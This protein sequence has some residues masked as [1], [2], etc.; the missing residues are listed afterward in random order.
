MTLQTA[1]KQSE[2]QPLAQSGFV[3]RVL[4]IITALSLALLSS[5]CDPEDIP[6]LAQA[7]DKAALPPPP[8]TSAEVGPQAWLEYPLE[9][10]TIPPEEPVPFVVYASDAEGVAQ[11]EL[12]V[13]GEPLPAT[14][15]QALSPDGSSRL[16]RLD[17]DWQAPAEGEYITE[18]RGRNTAGSYGEPTYVKFCVGSCQ[19]V[20]VTPSPAP[21]QVIPPAPAAQYDLYVRRMDFMQTNPIVGETIELFIMIATDTY[22][23]PGPFFPASYFRWRQGPNFPWQEESCPPNNQY[24]SCEK[25]VT[26]AYDQAG[27]YYVEV[28]ADS[29]QEVAESDLDHNR[30][31]G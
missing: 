19:P 31:L 2:C 14:Q 21:Q 1:N 29:R 7:P 11:V 20:T 8:E 15:A 22:P 17:Q 18:A 26:F 23:T 9:G 4:L 12:R 5:A 3:I 16:V 6:G 27:S 24:A 28:E 10:Q 30:R 13:N 25:T